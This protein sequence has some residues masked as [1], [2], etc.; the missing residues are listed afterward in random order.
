MF[1]CDFT[2]LFGDFFWI[3]RYLAGLFRIFVVVAVVVIII[4]II[5]IIYYYYYFYHHH[6]HT[7][8][9]LR[10]FTS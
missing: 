9:T 3:L 10:Y 5:I 1:F 8:E 2:M 4:I 7:F 6:H